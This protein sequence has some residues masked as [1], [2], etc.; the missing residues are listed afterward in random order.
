MP[1]ALVVFVTVPGQ[2]LNAHGDGDAQQQSEG[3][4]AAIVVMEG[5]FGQQIRQCD[6]DKKTS[7]D[8]Q[9][10]AEDSVAAARVGR[11]QTCGP[12]IHHQRP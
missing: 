10:P 12:D 7:G 3:Q 1:V 5:D 9:S 2:T 4:L 8:G 6:A 11:S